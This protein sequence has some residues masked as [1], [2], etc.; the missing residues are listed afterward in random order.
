VQ[1]QD[2][3]LAIASAVGAAAL[4]LAWAVAEAAR[5]RTAVAARRHTIAAHERVV[6]E[7]VA[8]KWAF[9]AGQPERG[10]QIVTNALDQAQ[11][12]VWR[13]RRRCSSGR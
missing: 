4:A 9:E 8:A 2:R 13:M 11:D 3:A 6:Q 1:R 12:A 7:L 10:L 5:T